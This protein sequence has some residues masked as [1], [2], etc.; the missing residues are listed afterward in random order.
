MSRALIISL[1]MSASVVLAACSGAASPAAAPASPAA[2]SASPAA[3]DAVT[4]Q[5][6]AFAPATLTVKSGATVTWTNNDASMHSVKWDDGT[7]GSAP[8]ATGATYTRTF[9][10]P[11]TYSYVCGIHSSMKGTIV[12]N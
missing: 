9:A 7:S 4:I 12:V 5:D 2:A 8:L 3:A 1:A 10:T 6:F 11:G